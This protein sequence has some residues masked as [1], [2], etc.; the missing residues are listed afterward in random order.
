M[1]TNAWS[2][3]LRRVALVG[4][5]AFATAFAPL[6]VAP[7]PA[8]A[9]PVTGFN[10]G[11]IIS[12]SLF[13][14]GNA[15]TA[16]EVQSFLNQ[17]V[18]RC[19]IGDPGRAA[20]SAWGN[21][22]IASKCLRNFSMNTTT[23]AANANCAAY[24]GRS[25]ETA[26]EIITRVG[27]ACGISQKVL[28]VM[29]EKEQSLVSDTWPTVRQFDVAMGYACPDSGPGN[30]ANCD[31]TYAGFFNQVYLSAWQLKNYKLYWN[32]FAYK[33]FQNNS[34]QWHPTASCGRSTVYIEN[35]ATAALYIYTPYRPNQAALNAG[36]GTGDSCSSYGNRNFYL[37]YTTW[38]GSAQGPSFP[39]TG[40]IESYWNANKSWLG[41]PTAAARN[42]ASSGGGRLQDFDGGFVYESTG[43]V[44]VGITRTSQVLTSF[45]AAGGIEG[46]WGWPISPATNQGVSGNNVMQFQ[47]GTVVEANEI[48]V[49]LIPNTLVS[50]WQSTGGFHGSLGAPT[51]SATVVGAYLS[52]R[53]QKQAVVRHD[54]GS[55]SLF[56]LRFFGSWEN[57]GGA[58]NS[59]GLPT[60][61]AVEIAGAGGGQEYPMSGGKMYRSAAGVFAIP[62]GN[63]LTA[64]MEAG[65]PA[66]AW[67]WPTG[68]PLCSSDGTQCSGTFTGGIAVWTERRGSQFTGYS[69]PS[70]TRV[71]P[72]SGE[73]VTG[74]V[75]Q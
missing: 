8:Q 54:S 61:A 66:G 53:F 36:W 1:K 60:G 62:N 49:F 46:S 45:S 30:S 69:A 11:N 22:T 47:G 40:G 19:T 38:F 14:N 74:G 5:L 28:L 65:G 71:I 64:Y 26:A 18:T 34:I 32:T 17:R 70:I 15:M 24:T 35:W 68:K 63:L 52:Q 21:T 41:M 48:G 6:V 25:G 56:D 2:S 67:G 27:Q 7:A 55:V 3:R 58:S 57:L 50:Y 33:P 13:Y 31:M 16:S 72:G 73:S 23:K 51:A 59:I 20:G 44:P 37:M 9:A 75:V 39:V 42:I 12:D 4:A 10:P 29:L 43:G